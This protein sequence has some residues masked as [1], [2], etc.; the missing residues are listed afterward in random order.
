M[1]SRP[2][3]FSA[4]PD[5]QRAHF[6]DLDD[7]GDER[8]KK[9]IKKAPASTAP[10]PPKS[11]RR[12]TASLVGKRRLQSTRRP[13]QLFDETDDEDE[14]PED[15]LPDY[16]KKRRNDMAIQHKDGGDMG[17]RLPPKHDETDTAPDE[18]LEAK[19]SLPGVTPPQ[20]FEKIRLGKQTHIPASIA[21]YLKPY[22]IDG[23]KWLYKKFENQE[24]ALLG[25]DMGL[26]KTIQVISFLTAAFGKTGD[27]RDSKRMRKFRKKS[28][29]GWYPRV[30]IV[31]PGTLIENWKAEFDRWGY[32]LIYTY[33]G[34]EKEAALAAAEAGM[35]E[36]MI[37]T[38]DTYKRDESAIN[39]VPWDC[40]IAD[41]CHTI[42][43][44][45][46]QNT[47][48]MSNINALCRIGLSGTAIQN[49]Y[50]ELWTLLNWANPG[51][52]SSVGNWKSTICVPLKMGQ[53]HDA[54]LSQLAKAR[55]IATQLSQNLLPNFF[56][57]RTKALIAHQLPKK[58]DRVVFCP[59]TETQV[60]AYQNFTDSELVHAIRDASEPCFCGSGKKQGWCCR[61][62]IEG[63]GE[64]QH[65]V[66]P[67]LVTLQKLANHVALMVPKA[68]SDA[69]RLEKDLEKLKIALPDSWEEWYS[70]RENLA[71]L[72]KPEFCGKWNVLK[73][74][75]KLWYENGDKVLIFSHSVRLLRMLD[76]LL[77]FKTD[78]NLCFL[79]GSMSY[80]ERQKAVDD[81]NS[82]PSQFA[83]LISTKAGGV[84]LNITS[85]NK[86][87]V[88]DP[89]WN[90]AYD[91]QAQDRAYRIGQTRDV[92]VFRLVSAGTVEEIVYARQ[93]YKQQQAAIG[94]N[95][96]IE[97][98][99]FKGVQ[100]QKDQKG[101]IFGLANLFAPNQTN[102]VLRDIVNK[103]NIAESRAGVEVA[104]LDLEVS[105]E[106]EGD[107]LNPDQEDAAIHALA[108][109]IIDEPGRKRKLAQETAKKRDPVQA[110]LASAGVA[111]T[112][113]NAEVIGTSKIETKLSSR[114]QK[115]ADDPDY[116]NEFAFARS[117]HSQTTVPADRD[118]RNDR[119]YE[120][121]GDGE[122]DT[123]EEVKVK[124]RFQPPE[125]VRR[126][127]FCSMAAQFGYD[128]VAEFALVV[129]G[130][131]QQQRRDCLETF[132]RQRKSLVV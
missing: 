67:A 109:E 89:N 124:Y 65:H 47:K 99:Y 5:A 57:R 56:K 103:T 20:P 3:L 42:K 68:E 2:S 128:D 25:D 66:F 92:E 36:I 48:A 1:S 85:A 46:S 130:W 34:N 52:V 60:T 63:F 44:R 127:Q 101:E 49:K 28:P 105:Q 108:A 121:N 43:E 131:T 27:E 11:A 120:E 113:E 88:V 22:Q 58:S 4:Q 12:K 38:Y 13:R 17:L 114:A 45:T 102:V 98:R 54:T 31:C 96:S 94:Y 111:Y 95:A 91:L 23:V 53:S 87:V 69:E 19:P 62:Y 30:L 75:M 32:W 83:F 122:V 78:Y 61:R 123:S 110:I 86:V 90:P 10:P 35:L 126:R 107:E 132:Y 106:D 76:L 117:Q 100:D 71:Y 97:R 6:S 39:C 29:G 70:N 33:H 9:R 118:M 59:L 115:G 73:K 18:R 16:L 79:N 21:Q 8:K 15:L 64:W 80:A 7:S 40:V 51:C 55:R 104:G 41:E 77:K 125:E 129:E 14:R 26:G 93:I 37:T 112:H 81:F 24:G 50:E 74:L 119:V 116:I 84:G 82:D 72:A